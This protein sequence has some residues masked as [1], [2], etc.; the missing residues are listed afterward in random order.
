MIILQTPMLKY[1]L[2]QL[3]NCN[4]YKNALESA[5]R[6]TAKLLPS[7]N[8]SIKTNEKLAN[9]LFETHFHVCTSIEDRTDE[10][11]KW[12]EFMHSNHP[13]NKRMT[14]EPLKQV[15]VA[16]VQIPNT[17]DKEEPAAEEATYKFIQTILIHDLVHYILVILFSL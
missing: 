17:K 8:I 15:L 2:N 9:T 4:E 12:E 16:R 3:N 10:N 1:V 14:P 11:R 6:Q 13:N 7:C 5:R